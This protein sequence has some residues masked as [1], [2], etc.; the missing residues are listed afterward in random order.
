MNNNWIYK[1]GGDFH[2][3]NA[4]KVLKKV[5]EGRKNKKFRLVKI[6]DTPVTYKEIEVKD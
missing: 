3:K 4:D 2:K 1:E 5:K 6:N